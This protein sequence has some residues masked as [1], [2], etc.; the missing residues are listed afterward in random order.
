MFRFMRRGIHL[1]S[2]R[3]HLIVLV[4]FGPI[5]P[6][7]PLFTDQQVWEVDLLELQFDWFDKLR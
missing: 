3:V 6:C 5:Q 7:V 1:Y 4:R 2:L